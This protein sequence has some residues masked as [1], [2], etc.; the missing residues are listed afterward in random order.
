MNDE[1][2]LFEEQTTEEVTVGSVT[3]KIRYAP[4]TLAVKKENSPNSAN[5]GA[6]P[7][8]ESKTYDSYQ[9][10]FAASLIDSTCPYP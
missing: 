2:R 1:N 3:V 4:V 5:N 9:I 7:A 6:D 10:I 8:L